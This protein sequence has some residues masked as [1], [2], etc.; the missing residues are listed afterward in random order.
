MR[1]LSWGLLLLASCS[2]PDPREDAALFENADE[3][4]RRAVSTVYYFENAR[5]VFS[6]VLPRRGPAEVHGEWSQAAVENFR[7]RGIGL[8]RRF[9]HERDVASAQRDALEEYFA[10]LPAGASERTLSLDPKPPSAAPRKE[11]SNDVC[12]Y[13]IETE[14]EPRAPAPA[15]V[16]ILHVSNGG[17]TKTLTVILALSHKLPAGVAAGGELLE[18][19]HRRMQ[20]IAAP[21]IDLSGFR[22]ISR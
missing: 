11:S 16:R 13:D 20:R 5:A 1:R 12:I 10:G 22:W 6:V 15:R 19:I 7:R 14:S 18:T 9:S 4:T 17:E 2:S 8:S 21:E 3:R